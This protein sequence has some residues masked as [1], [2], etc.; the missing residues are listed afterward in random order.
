[1]RR[2]F[3]RAFRR[4]IAP[5]VPNRIALSSTSYSAMCRNVGSNSDAKGPFKCCEHC[6]ELS[7]GL[8]VQ[9]N[10]GD[11][12]LK[13]IT[14]ECIITKAELGALNSWKGSV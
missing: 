7:A 9:T 1:M 13:E 3:G 4:M 11:Q 10:E 12:K 14:N 2:G 5:Y 8:G 6:K